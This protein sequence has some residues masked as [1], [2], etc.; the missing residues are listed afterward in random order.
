MN[1][2]LISET[3]K[4]KCKIAGLQDA[5]KAFKKY[6]KERKQYY[7]QTLVK[8]GQLESYVEELEEILH[9]ND[10]KDLKAKCARQA[11]ELRQLN[12]QISNMKLLDKYKGISDDELEGI[13]DEKDVI[14]LKL[15]IVNLK[16]LNK[17]LSSERRTFRKTVSSLQKQVNDLMY[18]KVQWQQSL[19]K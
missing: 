19:K 4:L 11:N 15:I 7:S 17:V 5:I 10:K 1:E 6:D 13:K 9:S 12:R 16:R 2:I 8:L 18:Y 14:Q 3:D